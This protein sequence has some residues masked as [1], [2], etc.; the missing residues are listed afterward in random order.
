[1]NQIKMVKAMEFI[2]PALKPVSEVQPGQDPEEYQFGDKHVFVGRYHGV[3]VG[4]STAAEALNLLYR[5]PN[6]LKNNVHNTIIVGW[7][8]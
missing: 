1:M 4:T 7:E 2:S 3:V 8:V 6:W 5:I